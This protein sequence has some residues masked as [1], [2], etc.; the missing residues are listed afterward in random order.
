MKSV[1]SLI[2]GF[3]YE[4]ME[5][6]TAMIDKSGEDTVMEGVRCLDEQSRFTH[7]ALIDNAIKLYIYYMKEN[8]PK[9]AEILARINHFIKFVEQGEVQTW[10]KL[11]ILRGLSQMQDAGLLGALSGEKLEMLKEKTNY[12]DFLDKKTLAL[13]GYPT[14]YFQVAM[15]CA[16]YREKLGWENEGFSE[17]L[18]EKLIGIM[19]N[20]SS[21][22]WMDERPPYGRFDRYSIIICAELADTLDAIGKPVPE[23]VLENLKKASTLVLEMS[24]VKGDGIVY[25]R[26]LSVHG[27]CAAA[28]IISTALRHG[29][30][31]KNNIDEAVAYSIKIFEKTFSF[32]YNEKIKSFDLWTNGRTTNKYRQIHR[33]LEVNL[34]MNNHLLCTLENF[35]KAGLAEYIPNKE[36]SAENTWSVS[37][38]VFSDGENGK[39]ALYI[40]KRGENMIM[41]PVIGAGDLWRCASYLPF[42]SS[43]RLLEAPPETY[44]PFLTPE[45]TLADGA[46]VMP[47]QYVNNTVFSSREDFAEITVCG[48]LC[49]M[50]V[51]APEKANGKFTAVYT[52]NK[53]EIKVN[54]K[55]DADVKEI[56]MVYAGAADVKAFGF[57]NEYIINTSENSDYFTPHGAPD[58]GKFWHAA[59]VAEK[60]GYTV[61]L[62]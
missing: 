41:L 20:C 18:K 54:Y 40:L 35:E 61:K 22:G 49:K 13:K 55:F 26:S 50:N 12:E 45:L 21:G 16:G 62:G 52:F 29:L 38:T 3:V 9:S 37:E 42:P 59:G 10:G 27:D 7:G 25:G 14:N 43:A 24:N 57:D 30:V 47:V 2:S 60:I 33:I 1:K 48:T 19:Q 51:F 23:F 39:Q 31:E 8:N 15:A 36:I 53:N 11:G 58:T 44:L 32:W 56:K 28:E 4:H 34:D 17:I 46:V 6:L 5:R